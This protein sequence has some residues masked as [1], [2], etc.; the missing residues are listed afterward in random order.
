MILRAELSQNRQFRIIFENQTSNPV[1]N[2]R[3]FHT[4]TRKKDF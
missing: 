1:K 2:S 4:E 3:N